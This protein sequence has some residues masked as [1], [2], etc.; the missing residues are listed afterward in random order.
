VVHRLY[1]GVLLLVFALLVAAFWSTFGSIVSIWQRSD[2]FSHGFLVLP[3]VGILIWYQRSRFASVRIGVDW[4]ALV[5]VLLLGLGW[6]LARL[7]D[8]L[9]IE[10]F[11]AVAM[12]PAVVWLVLGWRALLALTFPL[13]FLF[14]AVPFGEELVGPLMD[15]TASFTVSLLRLS[16]FPVYSEGT[17]FSIPSGDWSV[18]RACSGIRYLIASFFLGVL[19]AYVLYRSIWRRLAFVALSIV[20][21][22][23]ANGVRAYLIVVIAHFSDMKLAV[24]VDHL[25]YG[26]VFFG[27]VIFCMVAIG[28]LW[29]EKDA[30]KV[31]CDQRVHVE[32]EAEILSPS[33]T[34][35]VLIVGLGAVIL[36]GFPWLGSAL[37][38][39]RL[40]ASA[41]AD[42]A[43]PERVDV[44]LQS[45]APEDL[46]AWEP[47][48]VQPTAI[49]RGSYVDG[50]DRVALYWLPYL[51]GSGELINSEN[52]LV[53]EKDPTWRVLGQRRVFV[54]L[55]DTV[56]LDVIESRVES[57]GQTLLV[58]SWYWIN[59]R[60]T[61][62]D[63]E[64]KLLE[65]LAL[66]SGSRL[67]ESALMLVTEVDIDLDAAR[68][69][70]RR[71][72]R[73]LRG[74]LDEILRSG[75]DKP[76]LG[77]QNP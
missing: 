2:T 37:A 31:A 6:L 74:V 17:F 53:R 40:S 65:A 1:F 24:G 75:S 47:A 58:W 38:D 51:S 27:L 7:T 9:V 30:Q 68:N 72:S 25:I 46:T 71:F 50:E 62:S 11:S 76:R 60:Q 41:L 13:G 5:L 12:V 69:S 43:L 67:N 20:F 52:R 35:A 64:A 16:G 66:I 28:S 44:W 18:A 19:I 15:L 49:I 59:G 33:V 36:A 61:A 26:W 77:A 48:F 10:Q 14:F 3:I 39:R 22:I 63:T 32:V 42:I 23:L 56:D 70:V 29:V 55:T 21:P 4:R 54:T 45:D 34:K 73:D 57:N 8:V